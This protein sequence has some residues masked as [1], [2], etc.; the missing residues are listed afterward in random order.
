MRS[1]CPSF[2][3]TLCA[4]QGGP[5]GATMAARGLRAP[6]FPRGS[7]KAAGAA[8]AA[9]AARGAPLRVVAMPRIDGHGAARP[10][11]DGAAPSGN[12]SNGKHGTGAE[13]PRQMD[14]RG[15]NA[16]PRRSRTKG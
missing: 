8:P 4:A 5:A 7:T 15:G 6:T 2:Y 12:V 13:D 3:Q 14:E 11:R 10:A 1:P 16:R 9:I